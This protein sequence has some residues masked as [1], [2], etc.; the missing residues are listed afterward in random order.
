[1]VDLDAERKR[2]R[3]ELTQLDQRIAA[4]Q[5]KLANPGFVNKAPAAVVAGERQKL[6][7]LEV[8]AAKTRER[9]QELG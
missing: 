4:G 2:C 6:A 7:D 5:S 3:A 1:L 9:L 8:Q